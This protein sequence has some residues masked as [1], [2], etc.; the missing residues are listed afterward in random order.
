MILKLKV[1]L[2]NQN[3][4]KV[5]YHFQFFITAIINSVSHMHSSLMLNDT[6]EI[7]VDETCK[8]LDCERASVFLLDPK[9]NELWTKIAK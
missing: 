4:K 2:I 1:K 9:K 8:V 3:I 6:F 5:K 7:I